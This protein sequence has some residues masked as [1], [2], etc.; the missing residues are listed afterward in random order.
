MPDTETKPAPASD[1]PDELEAVS[2]YL[3]LIAACPQL[4]Q[5]APRIAEQTAE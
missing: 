2:A 4:R 3:L 5:S 1:Q